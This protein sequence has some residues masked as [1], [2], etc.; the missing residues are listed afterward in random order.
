MSDVTYNLNGSFKPTTKRFADLSGPDFSQH[1]GGRPLPSSTTKRSMVRFGSARAATAPCR[2][3][4]QKPGSLFAAL[5][6]TTE[7]TARQESIS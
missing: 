7:V 2:A 3:F 5:I 4:W 6:S 1:Q